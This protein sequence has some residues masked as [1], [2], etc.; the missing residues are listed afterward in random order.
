[1]TGNGMTED[2]RSE[3][4]WRT[5]VINAAFGVFVGIPMVS[6]LVAMAI[7]AIWLIV[8]FSHFL[9]AHSI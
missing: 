5:L 8:Q 2:S 3:P 6:A 1:M 9:A 4:S 7:L